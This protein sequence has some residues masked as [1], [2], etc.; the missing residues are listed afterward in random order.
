MV[1]TAQARRSRMAER[2]SL[3]GVTS[4]WTSKDGMTH[5]CL[6]WFLISPLYW[7]KRA[8]HAVFIDPE[9]TRA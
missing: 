2:V 8:W 9:K 7:K 1:R 4:A 3:A 6:W 5:E